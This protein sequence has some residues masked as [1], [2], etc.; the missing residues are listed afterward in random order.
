MMTFT[1]I[2][3]LTSSPWFH[4]LGAPVLWVGHF[5]ISYVLVEFACRLNLL[6]LD[7]TLLGLTILS[8]SVLVFTL[9]AT[10]ASLYVG[11]SAYKNLA[12]IEEKASEN[13]ISLMG[14]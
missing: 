7:S 4:L 12:A 14:N 2:S 11:W 13:R 8:W 6:V 10:F 3:R 5:V 9:M 1:P